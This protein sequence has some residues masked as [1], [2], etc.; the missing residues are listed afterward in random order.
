[1]KTLA[2]LDSHS[3][4]VKAS[5][6]YHLRVLRRFFGG[7]GVSFPPSLSLSSSSSSSSPSSSPLLMNKKILNIKSRKK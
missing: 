2:I 4:F 7:G 6:P 3:A 5:W 1:M